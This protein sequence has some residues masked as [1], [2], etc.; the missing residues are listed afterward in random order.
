VKSMFGL[1]LAAGVVL[2]FGAAW[3]LATRDGAG[4]LDQQWLFFT[5]LPYN[6]S[7]VAIFGESNFSADAPGEVVAAASSEAAVAYIAGA[8]AQ[9]ATRALWRRLRGARAQA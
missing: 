6:L 4:F 5:A 9:S 1:A 3:L 2:A 7:L 8:C